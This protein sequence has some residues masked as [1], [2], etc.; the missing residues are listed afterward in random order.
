MSNSKSVCSFFLFI[1]IIVG[2]L[3]NAQTTDTVTVIKKEKKVN[4]FVVPAL[5]S[6]PTAGFMY[7]IAGIAS[8]RLGPM[9]TTQISDAMV[10]I[11]YTTKKQSINLIKTN[12]FLKNDSWNLKGDWR[13][14]FSSQ[15]TYG[16]GTGPQ[17]AKPVGSTG[18]EYEPGLYGNPIS[19]EQMLGFSYFR[20]HENALKRIGDTRFFAGPGYQLDYHFNIDDKLLDTLTA[21]PTITSHYAYCIENGF[22]PDAYTLSGITLSA[23]Y[24][25]R[26]NTIFPVHG[27]YAY[28]SYRYNPEWMGSNKN[29]STLWMEYRNYFN[30]SKSRPRHLIGVWTFASIVTSG[31]VPYLDLPALGW[32]QFGKSG[33]GYTQGRFIG[34]QLLYGELEYRVPLPTIIKKYPDLLGAVAFVN[35]TTANNTAAN[36]DLFTY[37]DPG[38]GIGL[39][40]MT[41]PKT[42][43]NITLD[44]AWGKYGSK[45]IYFNFNETF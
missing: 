32:D 31:D 37:V 11:I 3:A 5:A 18:I 33:R 10:A 2:F 42:K 22:N 17:S 8:T 16:L 41:S 38:Y 14:F 15:P 34:K 12:I 1:L 36:I 35:A 19:G 29:S 39:R 27:Q 9:Q 44:Y 24:D 25:S 30:L 23:L 6:N 21:Q 4:T 45:G 20:F 28:L 26:D 40:I 13:V 43:A 7:G